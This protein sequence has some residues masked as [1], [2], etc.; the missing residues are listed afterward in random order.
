MGY[1]GFAFSE[2]EILRRRERTAHLRA[3]RIYRSEGKLP[4]RAQKPNSK[5]PLRAA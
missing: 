3:A 5:T 4:A 1:A 2:D